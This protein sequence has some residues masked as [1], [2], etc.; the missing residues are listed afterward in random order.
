MAKLSGEVTLPAVELKTQSWYMAFQVIQV[1][2]VTTFSSGA[3]SSAAQ[4]VSNPSSA[5]TLLVE[6]LPKASN[7][8]ISYFILQGLGIAAGDILNIGALAMLTVVGKFLDKSP[9]K[10]FKRFITLSGLGWGS[11]Y[12]KFGNLGIIGKTRSQLRRRNLTQ[13]KQ[14]H[15]P[16]SRRLSWALRQL[17]LLSSTS[18]YATILST[19]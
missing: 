9:R 11:M 13:L 6:N 10:M 14:S 16:L 2:L 17:V 18:L 5:T 4:I 3:A 19:S 15:T 8:Y 1:F 7:F 12:P